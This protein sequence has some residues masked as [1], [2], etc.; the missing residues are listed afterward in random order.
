MNK[1]RTTLYEAVRFNRQVDPI[2]VLELP[3]TLIF[4][5]WFV[6]LLAEPG[7]LL[8]TLSSPVASN[9]GLF[10]FFFKSLIPSHNA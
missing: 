5:P 6:S 9:G 1:A 7:L 3:N 2:N 8:D 4:L 10:F